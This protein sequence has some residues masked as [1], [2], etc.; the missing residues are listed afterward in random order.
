MLRCCCILPACN[1]HQLNIISSGMAMYPDAD[2][3][4]LLTPSAASLYNSKQAGVILQLNLA[5]QTPCS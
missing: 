1:Y 5:K 3:Y 4:G 2:Q